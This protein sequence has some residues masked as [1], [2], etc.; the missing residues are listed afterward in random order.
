[1]VSG[2]FKVRSVRWFRLFRSVRCIGCVAFLCL[3][4][5]HGQ[6][7]DTVRRNRR[8]ADSAGNPGSAAPASA[9]RT[10]SGRVVNALTGAPVP[11]ALVN[12]SSRVALTDP[13]GKFSFADFT[14]TTAYALVT[15]PG[16][17]D[18]PTAE[19][20]RQAR[21]ADLDAP[22]DLKLYP[23]ALITGLVTG[24]DGLPLGRIQV[25]LNRL[26]FDGA[27]PRWFPSG[28]TQTDTHG[29][30]RFDV[31]GGSYR[32]TTA[33][34]PRSLERGEAVLPE[35]FPAFSSSK[36]ETLKIAPGEQ[37]QVNLRPRVGPAYT[38]AIAVEG[39]DSSRG[40]MLTAITAAGRSFS[41]PTQHNGETLTVQLPAGSFTLRALVPGNPEKSMTGE[42]R[43]VVTGN[44]SAPVALRLT[45]NMDFPVESTF[46]FA[47]TASKRLN[48]STPSL[49]IFN[50]S[51]HDV[52][53]RDPGYYSQDTQLSVRPD[54][55]AGFKIR[56]GRY[57]LGGNFAGWHV[58]AATSGVTDLLMEELVVAQGSAGST[59]RLTLSNAIGSVRGSVRTAG[60][61]A[62]GWIY[63]IA[64]QP[65]LTAF[66]EVYVQ[67]N[68]TYQWYGPPGK[69]LAVPSAQMVRDDFRSNAFVR[70]C[71]AG[72]REVE[73]T[74]GADTSLDLTLAAEGVAR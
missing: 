73:I 24:P 11:R 17:S 46:E 3:P 42:S 39:V 10:I 44:S 13:Q 20:P 50:F 40:L 65:S 47:P 63:F 74:N 66:T 12:L 14:A 23:N 21:L 9:P 16:Y 62:T 18:V 56:P 45:A 52:V 28:Y 57:R 34:N 22:V 26:S 69:Y 60:L 49:Q 43:V 7:S 31:P 59:I 51:L 15:K 67:P 48:E 35:S 64:Q 58:T 1:M 70:K 53:D 6:L 41:I 37:R 4:S 2:R 5:L 30:Y 27:G 8:N 38:V 33:Y 25:Q 32:I 71:T 61:P 54:H 29:D 68:G 36:T 19:T 72:A 55:T